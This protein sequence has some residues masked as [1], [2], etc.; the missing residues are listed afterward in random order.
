MF[1]D[2][3]SQIIEKIKHIYPKTKKLC[4]KLLLLKSIKQEQSKTLIKILDQ[5][6]K[7]NIQE[8][9]EIANSFKGNNSIN[10][11]NNIDVMGILN[12]LKK[13]CI[14]EVNQSKNKNLQ[15]LLSKFIN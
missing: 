13:A 14:V 12:L 10:N 9:C 15:L 1:V 8:C 7:V 2:H 3:L 4:I 6:C 5:Y 11:E